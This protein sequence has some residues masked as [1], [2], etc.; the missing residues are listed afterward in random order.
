MYTESYSEQM[1]DTDNASMFSMYDPTIV[2]PEPMSEN[3]CSETDHPVYTDLSSAQYSFTTPKLTL[4]KQEKKEFAETFDNLLS[5]TSKH[6]EHWSRREVLD[7]VY[8]V[9]DVKK[10]DCSKLY[11]ERYQSLTGQKLCRMS[12][13]DFTSLDSHYGAILYSLFSSLV[14]KSI[15]SEPSPPDTLN[16][17]AYPFLHTTYPCLPVP[18]GATSDPSSTT[19]EHDLS[20]FIN[21][22]GVSVDIDG[23]FY[24]ID[25]ATKIDIPKIDCDYGYV[26]GGSDMES[27]MARCG[28][29]SSEP[30]DSFSISDE[31]EMQ[32]CSHFTQT[33]R[34][35]MS[36]SVSSDEDIE[37]KVVS[38]RKRITSTSKGN[39]LWEFIRDL[40]KDPNLNPSLLKWEDKESGV[41]K[42][43]QSEAVA[44][45]WGRKKNNPGMTYEKLSRA[46]RF[47]RTAGYF[48]D[49]PK[50]GKFPKKL[51]FRF[52]PKAHDWK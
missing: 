22:A 6:P 40:L 38:P 7:W 4:L 29:T 17:D 1:F 30:Y 43:V 14:Q 12:K 46:M 26:S 28:S 50:N 33:S 44:S 8:Y 19:T 35:R 39:H 18:F 11:G 24:D 34:R 21:D 42:F 49:V 20:V 13:E 3:S 16:P 52:G 37:E 36:P 27:N 10:F 51:C 9:A 32:T 23:N 48:G 2:K 45:M 31:E 15:F 41:F 25:V 47:C 5:W